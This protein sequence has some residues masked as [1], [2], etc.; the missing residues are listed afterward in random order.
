MQRADPNAFATDVAQKAGTGHHLWLVWQPMYKKHGVKCETIAA[1]LQAA[2][3]KNGGSGRTVVT[4]HTAL[5]YEPMNL[6][7][8]AAAGS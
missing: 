8:Y 1:D 5:Y 6:T 2:A 7:E 4:S 3:T